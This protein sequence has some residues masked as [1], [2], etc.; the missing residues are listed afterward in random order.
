LRQEKPAQ[1]RQ[2]P[3]DLPA[4]GVLFPQTLSVAG[5][6]AQK[7][8][9]AITVCKRYPPARRS[10]LSRVG[11][12]VM[13]LTRTF[14]RASW[15]CVT[16][17]AVAGCLSAQSALVTADGPSDNPASLVVSASEVAVAVPVPAIPPAIIRN[18]QITPIEQYVA[19]TEEQ[20]FHNYLWNAVGPVAFAGSSVA[21]AI[22]QA[23]SFPHAWG[24][25]AN[26]YGARVAS[27]LGIS[28]VTGTAQY[29]MAE[30][31]HED[32]A[33]YRCRC[34]GF[35]PRFWH[36]ALSSVAAR[37]GADGHTSFSIA[38]TASPFIGPIVAANSW[39]PSRNG[40]MLGLKMGEH[41]LMGQFGQNEALEFL[42][43]GPHT[44]LGR[45]LR[46]FK[47]SSDT[48]PRS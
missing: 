18:L 14:L 1:V 48:N 44:L 8:G 26:A 17:L 9:V 30:I 3:R 46:V 37:R 21:A 36:A 27:N 42:Y 41:N 2:L 47:R 43:G 19:P 13:V 22:D 29:S 35:F 38:L 31:F 4:I 11:N 40:P 34:T 28:L 20:E 24:Q 15:L 23:F 39:L 10:F 25:G 12:E 45:I 5:L 32:T 16:I 7:I 6:F 33:Y